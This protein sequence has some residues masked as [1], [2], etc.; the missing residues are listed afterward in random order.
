MQ[1]P[2]LKVDYEQN[3]YTLDKCVPFSSPHDGHGLFVFADPPTIGLKP[4]KLCE[5][6]A[7]QV[8]VRLEKP[9]GVGGPRE[10]IDSATENSKLRM[11]WQ[12]I[13]FASAPRRVLTGKAVA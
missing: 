5:E 12:R 8:G 7:D 6:A 1:P 11:R 9:A 3:E 13:R 4:L 2:H 10:Q